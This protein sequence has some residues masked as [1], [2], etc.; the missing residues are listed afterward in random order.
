MVTEQVWKGYLQ[1]GQIP[2]GIIEPIVFQSWNRCKEFRLDPLVEPVVNCLD[3]VELA[4]RKVTNSILLRASRP[5]VTNIMK[6][7]SIKN[8]LIVVSDKDGYILEIN[9]DIK[10]LN[11]VQAVGLVLGANW[12]E[13]FMGTNGIGTALA[14][15]QSVAIIGYDHYYKTF[16][17]LEWYTSPISDINGEICGTFSLV[18]TNTH[19]AEDY[20]GIAALAAQNIQLQLMEIDQFREMH[21]ATELN[22]Y[23]MESTPHGIMVI[24]NNGVIKFFNGVL[25]GFLSVTAREMVGKYVWEMVECCGDG[26]AGLKG[27]LM[28]SMQSGTYL[29]RISQTVKN[30]SGRDTECRVS[31]FPVKN[32]LNQ[33][34]AIVVV[35]HDILNLKSF[36]TP[37]EKPQGDY[38]SQS[39]FDPLTKLYNRNVF[40]EKLE[41][42]IKDN[43]GKSNPKPL[44]L[45]LLDIDHFRHYNE[46]MGYE[47]GDKLLAE[48]AFLIR[49][50]T[51]GKDIAARYG[52]EEF[53]IVLNG[54]EGDLC[55]K[56]AMR[57]K[58]KIENYHFPGR[59]MQPGGKL[60]LSIGVAAFP[61]NASTRE[62]L[63]K[64]AEEA[65][66][67][68]QKSRINKISFYFTVFDELKNELNHSDLS[69]LNTIRTLITVINAKDRYTYGHSER[70]VLYATALA[71]SIGLPDKDIKYLRY[72]AYLHDIG[73]I[74][75]S[76]ELL[77]KK[78]RLTSEEWEMLK[79]HP[80]W[81]AEIIKPVSALRMILPQIL[82]HHERWD[83]KGY[84]EGL[85]GKEI[86]LTARILT[87]ADCF[88]AMTTDRP[89]QKGVSLERALEQLEQEAGKIFDPYLVRE[90]KLIAKDIF[91]KISN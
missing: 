77:N 23:L 83:G 58:E 53:A 91:S 65:L 73:K 25:E 12:H 22:Q 32:Q 52:G 11:H 14:T 37:M 18:K 90:F 20:L 86:P 67:E 28:Q 5:T 9:G 59:E 80:Q 40:H 88:D 70:V 3:D 41:E 56:L 19:K 26:L 17:N 34:S 48:I 82:Y 27:L 60:T 71:K 55:G 89:Y 79:N 72:G 84:P 87:I 76:R 62:E 24:D 69:L 74:E 2:S 47:A 8:F 51:R 64:A 63:I 33:L 30:R 4:E 38:C 13:K 10:V 44:A 31:T 39:I 54:V 16:H 85:A 21:L 50:N 1:T 7:F 43:K 66:I 29:S 42:M 6:N 45:L 75:I 81:G 49:K 35:I 36:V 57:I 46:V 68:A 78:E 61:R 15:K